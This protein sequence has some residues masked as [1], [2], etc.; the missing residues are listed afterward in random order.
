VITRQKLRRETRDWLQRGAFALD[1]Y[2]RRFGEI[3]TDDPHAADFA[4]FGERSRIEAPRIAIVN[5]AAVAIGDDVY[6]RSHLCLE[7]YAHPGVV[8][9]RFRNDIQVGYNVRFVA[10][11]GI[12]VCDLAGIGHGC[13]ISDSVHLWKEAGDDEAMWKTP[14]AVGRSLRIER[15]VWIGNNCVITG[16][17]TIGESAIIGPNSVITRDVPPFTI[18]GGN[19]AHVER[20]RLSSGEWETLS[21]P[22]P[23]PD[24]VAEHAAA[25]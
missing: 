2:A 11:N 19:P 17:V 5:P 20:R 13:T 16:G 7:A 1:R 23:L 25:G 15:R 6:I 3:R 21:T 14:P 4:S 12:E 9:I 24:Y 18:V 22:V 10:F 8:K